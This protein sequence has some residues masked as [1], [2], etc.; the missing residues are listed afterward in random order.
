MSN[1]RGSDKMIINS[2]LPKVGAR[3]RSFVLRMTSKGFNAKATC[4]VIVHFLK[5]LNMFLNLVRATLGKDNGSH[6]VYVLIWTRE[7]TD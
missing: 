7:Q 1:I 5:C 6:V 3:N 4:S 2:V